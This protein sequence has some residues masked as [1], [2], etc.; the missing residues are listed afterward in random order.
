MCGGHIPCGAH[1]D[2]NASQSESVGCEAG[3]EQP[4]STRRLTLPRRGDGRFDTKNVSVRSMASPVLRNAAT[5]V[6][7]DV[8]H[9]EVHI[10][11][12][13]DE[14]WSLLKASSF[15]IVRSGR[16]CGS[17]HRLL[18]QLLRSSQSRM[19]A[20]AS[21]RHC[22][23]ACERQWTFEAS[24]QMTWDH[25]AII[26]EHVRTLASFVPE[27]PSLCGDLGLLLTRASD[28]ESVT[29]SHFRESL[30]L[31][32]SALSLMSDTSVSI[33]EDWPHAAN[34][35]IALRQ[36]GKIMRYQGR[37]S[38]ATLVTH[39]A[40]A[41][42]HALYRDDC[43]VEVVDTLH[44][45]GLLYTRTGRLDVA[46]RFLRQALEMKRTLAKRGNESDITLDVASTLYA[47]SRVVMLEKPKPKLK[48]AESLLLMALDMG[49]AGVARAS[50][51]QQL[52]RIAVRRG[53]SGYEKNAKRYLFEALRIQRETYCTDRHVNVAA[54][55]MQIGTLIMQ[56]A[57]AE[58]CPCAKHKSRDVA[59]K[60]IE[61]GENVVGDTA[62]DMKCQYT[63]S[64]DIAAG[65][66]EAALR[67]R[68][69]IYGDQP[70]LDVA[71][72]LGMLGRLEMMRLNVGRAQAYAEE[73]ITCLRAML[74][75]EHAWHTASPMSLLSSPPLLPC[76]R[77][78]SAMSSH[79]L[80]SL[81]L[82]PRACDDGKS[83][84]GID[85]RQRID[86][87]VQRKRVQRRPRQDS[88][89]GD[90][91][92]RGELEDLLVACGV[93]RGQIA[94]IESS[95]MESSVPSPNTSPRHAPS[96][97]DKIDST[98]SSSPIIVGSDFCRALNELI[99]AYALL[100]TI[101]KR[102]NGE[103]TNAKRLTALIQK[104][105]RRL[106]SQ[107]CRMSV[108]CVNGNGHGADT[109]NA[110]VALGS[111][112]ETRSGRCGD[113][114]NITA[115]T[116]TT[117]TT[118]ATEMG[119]PSAHT[120]ALVLSTFKRSLEKVKRLRNFIRSELIRIGSWNNTEDDACN[121]DLRATNL[122]RWRELHVEASECLKADRSSA[123]SVHSSSADDMGANKEYDDSSLTMFSDA[124]ATFLSQTCP[125]GL[126]EQSESSKA[127]NRRLLDCRQA[128]FHSCDTVRSK[129]RQAG[130]GFEDR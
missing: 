84:D 88:S 61:D 23:R 81:E 20:E 8:R 108:P 9:S 104:L 4:P 87:T 116:T 85:T 99:E 76:S 42:Q 122:T 25:T 82:P 67:V 53:Q 73:Q 115:R 128:L 38:L 45:L 28:Y 107:K 49:C 24:K 17:M 33:V 44:E 10:N 101:S 69:S 3:R 127:Y 64:L 68:R 110:I 125:L 118:G 59:M 90:R 5:A 74:Q 32:V 27:H 37:L 97:L 30:T 89:E 78:S 72:S 119:M 113:V 2:P 26:L 124:L 123:R 117:T 58:S 31:A 46:D 48:R 106:Q 109:G 19:T 66:L 29:R 55:R 60:H 43:R 126:F 95:S 102:T 41:I 114:K 79:E 57:S 93:Y 13:L 54:V 52:A 94:Q 35:S 92:M 71:R 12:L 100:R 91:M 50:T 14:C 11:E 103:E 1:D 98:D 96:S 6:S 86:V 80:E 65:H 7:F 77:T 22:V 105:R 36:I 56:I 121:V 62:R 39:R 75:S 130:D 83:V 129:I 112:A 34:A 70:H 21:I 40:L 15:L 16:N 120:K 51:L 18:Q 63:A 111:R 47:L